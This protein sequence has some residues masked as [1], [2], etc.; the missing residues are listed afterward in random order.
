MIHQRKIL[1]LTSKTGGGH[2]SLAEALRE[3]LQ[4]DY[5]IKIEDL[6]PGLFPRHYRFVA[7]NARWL[8]SLE[9][10]LSDTPRIALLGH[11]MMIPLITPRFQPIM[12]RFQPDLVLSVH[13]W[14]SFA[15]VM[16]TVGGL[17][18]LPF[19]NPFVMESQHTVTLL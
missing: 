5:A 10:H 2:V 11:L 12:Q 16:G 15:P 18:E 1:I 19:C 14:R 9:Y 3:R 4:Q 8:W 17:G 7:Q 6:L 13:P